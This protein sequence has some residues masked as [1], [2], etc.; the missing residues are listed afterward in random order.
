[1]FNKKITVVTAVITFIIV[2]SLICFFHHVEDTKNVTSTE[3]VPMVMVTKEVEIF[4]VND[5]RLNSNELP[6]II[7]RYSNLIE[8]DRKQIDCL[9]KNM[10]HEAGFEPRDGIFAV[11][12]VTM[13]RMYSGKFPQTVCDVVYQKTGN[14]YQFSWVP[15]R[16]SLTKIDQEVYNR[17]LEKAIHIYFNYHHMVDV[18][19]GALFFHA[20]Y[21][22][23]GWKREKVAH[24]GRHIFYR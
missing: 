24:I 4:K 7:F 18:T 19:R 12:M 17:I 14:F 9:A 2:T 13:N 21:I 20:D 16:N 1:M 6:P 8:Y 22:K 23:P 11:G 5:N 10:Y 15:I 3:I